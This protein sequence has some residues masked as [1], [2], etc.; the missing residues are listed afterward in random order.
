MLERLNKLLDVM[1]EYFAERKGLLPLLG[2]LLVLINGILQ[3]LPFPGWL[4]DSD[5]FLHIGVILAIFG[6]LLAWAL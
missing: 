3:F 4:V 6:F 2:I 1:S 5:L